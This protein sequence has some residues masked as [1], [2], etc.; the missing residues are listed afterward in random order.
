[1]N[2]ETLSRLTFGTVVAVAYITLVVGYL[3]MLRL[4]PF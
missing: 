2:S 1:M 3:A 4:P